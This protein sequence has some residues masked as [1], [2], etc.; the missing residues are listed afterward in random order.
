MKIIAKILLNMEHIKLWKNTLVIK[1]VIMKKN[2][3]EK[4]RNLKMN[5]L[6][7]IEI[8]RIQLAE[9]HVHEASALAR[10]LLDD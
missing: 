3:K 10:S 9:L 4:K 8:K 2:L 1:K 7:I 5:I 6:L